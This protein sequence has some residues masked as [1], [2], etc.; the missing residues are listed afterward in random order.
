MRAYVT[1]IGEPT[2][3]LCAWSLRRLGYDV[4]VLQDPFTTLQQKLKL[5]YL[6]ADDDFIRVDADVVCNKYLPAMVLSLQA[7]PDTWWL[8]GQ[9]FDWFKQDVTN[10]GVQ[11][12]RKEALPILRAH[13][14]EAAGQERPESFLYR[15]PEFHNPR[16]CFVFNGIVGLHGYGQTDI[17]RVKATKAR[18]DQM[19]AHDFELAER[20][21][22]L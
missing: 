17:E 18:R 3:E 14:D 16:R 1:S 4:R 22:A 11:L 2:A 21:N 20:L 12:I 7:Q 9:T 5:I 8:A 19:E 10:G 6:D 13:V 15:L